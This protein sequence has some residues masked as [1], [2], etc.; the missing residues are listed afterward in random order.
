[1]KKFMI[2]ALCGLSLFAA[3][4]FANVANSNVPAVA[5]FGLH[6]RP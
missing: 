1:M 2:G 4:A 3:V 5:A 6:V